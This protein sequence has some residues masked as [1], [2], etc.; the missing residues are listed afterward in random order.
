[1]LLKQGVDMEIM[2]LAK[3]LYVD[4]EYDIQT[5]VK[6]SLQTIGGYDV[7]ICDLAANALRCIEEYDPDLLLLD[8]M[9]PEMDGPTLLKKIRT[10]AMFDKVPAIFMTAKAQ[11]T[12]IALLNSYPG[13]AGVIVK[14][15]NP[16]ELPAQ[17]NDLWRQYHGL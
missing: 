10:I 4:D 6:L 15:F 9:M 2:Q 3:I 12:E 7:K 1:M 11:K 5:V 17:I 13:V 14:P 8:V 16:V